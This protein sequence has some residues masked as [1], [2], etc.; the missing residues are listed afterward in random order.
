M[1]DPRRSWNHT[2]E[3]LQKRGLVRD[4]GFSDQTCACISALLELKVHRPKRGTEASNKFNERIQHKIDQLAL[5]I[6][7]ESAKNEWFMIS[8]VK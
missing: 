6:T 4:D 8:C 1:Q 5:R 2:A 3:G 7:M